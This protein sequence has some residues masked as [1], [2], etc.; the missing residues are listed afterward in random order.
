MDRVLVLRGR[1][2]VSECFLKGNLSPATVMVEPERYT[3]SYIVIPTR[4][5]QYL[6]TNNK[7][8]TDDVTVKEIPYTEVSNQ[9]GTTCSIAS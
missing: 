2:S 9:F 4:E 5:D 1:L 7:L 6:A 3:G 8:M